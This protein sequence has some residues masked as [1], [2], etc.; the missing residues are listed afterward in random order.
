MPP[1]RRYGHE[2][3]AVF[4][5][6]A[7]VTKVDPPTPDAAAA[8]SLAASIVWPLVLGAIQVWALAVIGSLAAPR[9]S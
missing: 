5:G 8:V 3:I 4:T 1:G 2:A 9:P 6:A 7:S